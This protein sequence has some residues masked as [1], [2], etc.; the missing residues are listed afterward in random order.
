MEK[1]ACDMS[2][3]VCVHVRACV[4]CMHVHTRVHRN[5]LH[6]NDCRMG[7]KISTKG[8]KL[9]YRKVKQ[10]VTSKGKPWASWLH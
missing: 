1:D 4:E 10:T 2:P 8:G 3:I 5:A 9:K 7:L 6:L